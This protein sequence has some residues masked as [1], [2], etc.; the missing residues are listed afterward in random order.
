MDITTRN[1][2]KLLRAGT[3]GSEE[4]IEPMSAWKWNQ[5]YAYA[6]SHHVAALL[7]DGVER[8]S[9]QFFMQLPDTLRQVWSESTRQTEEAF[10]RQTAVTAELTDIY[11]RMHV[12]PILVQGAALAHLYETPAHRLPETISVFLPFDTQGAKA[13]EW[14]RGNASITAD[15]DRVFTFEWKEEKVENRHRLLNLT[16]QLHQHTLKHIVEQSIR[17][18]QATYTQINGVRIE[19]LSPTL[20]MLLLLLQI[21]KAMLNEGI[22]LKNVVDMGVFLRR[23]GDRVDFVTLQEWTS[24]LGLQRVAN[25]TGS[26]LIVLLNFGEDELPFV[27]VQKKQDAK[28]SETVLHN[29]RNASVEDWYFKQGTDVFVHTANTSAMIE[30]LRHSMRYFG[31]YPSESITNFFSV[32]AHSLSHIEE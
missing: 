4:E 12:R 9:S 24:K 28:Q 15:A 26:L 23:Q 20:S 27:T 18:E 5:V 8:C 2:F 30:H 17:Q 13:D 22:C 1:F 3:F 19:T 25:L 14:A 6:L 31:Y 11:G 16:N 21:A 29:C 7:W 10:R 32:F